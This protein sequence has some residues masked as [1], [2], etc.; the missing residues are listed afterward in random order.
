MPELTGLDELTETPHAVVFDTD[1]PRTVRLELE[2]GEEIPPHRHP[3]TNVV[4]Y[5][6]SGALELTLDGETYSLSAD[7]VIRFDGNQDIS[8]RAVEPSTALVVFA[9]AV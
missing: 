2:A 9:P 6:Q 1:D 5:L 3:D 4:L 7:D 8:P